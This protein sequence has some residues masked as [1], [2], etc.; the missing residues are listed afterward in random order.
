MIGAGYVRVDFGI[1]QLFIQCG[2]SDEIV[3]TPSGVLFSCLEAV[4]PPGLNAL[5]VG[6]EMPEGI[7]K[8]RV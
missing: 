7:G 8:A 2:G 1:R 3:N 6:I 5:S 4:G